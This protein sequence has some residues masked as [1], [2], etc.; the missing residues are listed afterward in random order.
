MIEM[1][2]LM[3]DALLGGIWALI[4]SVSPWWPWL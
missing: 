3:L 4:E 1:L 2:M